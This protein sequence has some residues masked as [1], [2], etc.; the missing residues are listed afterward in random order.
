MPACSTNTTA[1]LMSQRRPF[2]LSIHAG[3]G[4]SDIAI[5]SSGNYSRGL[6]ACRLGT[7]VKNIG[8]D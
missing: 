5:R 4:L 1:A 3:P 6:A 2:V 8:T 7:Y